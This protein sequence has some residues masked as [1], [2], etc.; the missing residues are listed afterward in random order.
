MDHEGVGSPVTYAECFQWFVAPTDLAG[1]SPRA[2]LAPDVINNSWGCTESEGCEDVDILETVV[3]NT[4]AAGIVVITS[5]GNGGSACSTV[6]T[7]PAIYEASFAV[8]AVDA[9]N[10]PTSFSSRGPVTVDGSGRMKPDVAAPGENIRSAAPWLN[11]DTYV[12]NSGTSMAAPHVA[13][14]I[15]LLISVDPDLAGDP[16]ALELAIGDAADHPATSTQTC[17]G[18]SATNFPNNTFGAGRVNALTAVQARLAG[19]LVFRDGFELRGASRWS[20]P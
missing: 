16:D 17:G 13:G 8:G 18:V 3:E 12:Y 11:G 15:A 6:S 10:V 20:V 1:Q 14:L 4:R 9:S 5:A 19:G 2:D 7:P